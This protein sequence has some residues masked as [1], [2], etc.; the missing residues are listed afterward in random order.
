MANWPATLQQKVNEGGFRKSFGST[1]I[2]SNNDVGPA[3]VRRRFTKRIDNHNI[4]MNLSRDQY[5]T[6][7]NFY[8]T[9]LNGG[10]ESFTFIDPITD[11][12]QTYRFVGDPAI[13]PIGGNEFLLQM[14]WEQLP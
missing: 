5:D 3:K 12:E 2:T 13:T 6:F 9:T 11:T 14:V 1:K 4:T 8:D 10:V 7:N